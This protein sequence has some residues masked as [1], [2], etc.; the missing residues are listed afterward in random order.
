MGA[1]SEFFSGQFGV[2]VFVAAAMAMSALVRL[3]RSRRG[4]PVRTV[5]R[6]NSHYTSQ[7]VRDTET[8]HRWTGIDLDGIHEANRD[9]VV[10]LL[11][12]LQ[13]GGVDALRPI[14]QMFLD[15][16][17]GAPEPRLTDGTR[18]VEPQATQEPHYRPA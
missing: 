16:L 8:R 13:A 12:R 3:L 4:R 7:A 1:L 17:A 14:E 9:E 6:P 2:I 15:Q 18:N 5:E 11:A 10:G